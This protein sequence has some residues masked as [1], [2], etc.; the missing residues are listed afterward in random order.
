MKSCIKFILL[1]I[2]LKKRKS[3]RA[4][5][6]PLFL[7]L[8]LCL[9]VVFICSCH[10]KVSHDVSYSV[11]G[12]VID[13]ESEKPIV[14][15]E[16]LLGNF[17]IDST[18]TAGYYRYTSWGGNVHLK[19]TARAEGYLPSQKEVFVPKNSSVRVDF[20]LTKE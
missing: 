7:T 17:I 11:Y 16:I 18:D 13:A 5:S 6:K 2:S 12:Y 14:N 8:I 15:V 10:K 4:L 3:I 9:A 20:A 19:I 1:K